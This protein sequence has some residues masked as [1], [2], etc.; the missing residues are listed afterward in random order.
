MSLHRH[1]GIAPLLLGNSLD[2]GRDDLISKFLQNVP[3]VFVE[4]FTA[5]YGRHFVRRKVHDIFVLAA[6][7]SG[8]GP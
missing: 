2:K 1:R 8:D 3:A 4:N 5:E 6:N 7:L